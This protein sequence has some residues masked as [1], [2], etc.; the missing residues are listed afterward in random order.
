MSVPAGQPL[1][2]AAMIIVGPSVTTDHLTGTL[3][4]LPNQVSMARNVVF[5]EEDSWA[6]AAAPMAPFA[7]VVSS[8][9]MTT[10]GFLNGVEMRC[11]EQ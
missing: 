2:D 3:S 8:K 6:E 4:P 5:P 1:A 11:S 9:I 7:S 10:G